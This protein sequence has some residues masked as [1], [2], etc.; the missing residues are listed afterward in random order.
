MCVPTVRRLGVQLPCVSFRNSV[1]AGT[2]VPNIRIKVSASVTY[3]PVEGVSRR[4]T[5]SRRLRHSAGVRPLAAVQYLI[6]VLIAVVVLNLATAVPTM[7]ESNDGTV[8]GQVI[9]QTAGG[10]S[11]AGVSVILV[12]FGHK[13]QAPLGQLTNQ[14]D[15]TG[16]YTFTGLDRDPNI[17]YITVAR[18]QN[19]T[20]PS[21]Q[22][23]QLQN[24]AAALPDISV[25][26]ATTPDDAIQLESLNLLVMG[27]DQGTVQLMEMGALIN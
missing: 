25:Y 11:T 2:R 14:A 12:S 19:V 27:A 23:F 3:Q 8:S 24:Q 10:G 6:R 18:Y 5:W 21:D 1:A 20:Y 13:E 4:S 17:V 26:D 22:P 16:R 9:N 7:A 15:A